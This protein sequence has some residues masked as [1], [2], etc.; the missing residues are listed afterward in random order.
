[1]GQEARKGQGIK[2]MEE[3]L[4]LPKKISSVLGGEEGQNSR[5]RATQISRN[6]RSQKK[7]EEL[8]LILHEGGGDVNEG[9]FN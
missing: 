8:C 2:G 9:V 3:G 4:N 7:E 1:M 5:E 6:E